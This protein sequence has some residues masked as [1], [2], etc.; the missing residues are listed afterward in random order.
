MGKTNFQNLCSSKWVRFLA[1]VA[2]LAIVTIGPVLSFWRP[3]ALEVMRQQAL[4]EF[5][6][7][8]AAGGDDVHIIKSESDWV[9]TFGG[10]ASLP[11]LRRMST[12]ASLDE[13]GRKLAAH[14][15]AFIESGEHIRWFELELDPINR[16][17]LKWERRQLTE[18]ICQRDRQLRP[19]GAGP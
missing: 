16:C 18:Y 1:A 14:L 2:V 7:D 6:Y 8:H 9:F 12:D 13:H 11:E 10:S 3:I 19:K 5:R 4:A 17:E 15:A